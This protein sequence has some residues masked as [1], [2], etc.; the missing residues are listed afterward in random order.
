MISEFPTP[1]I[2]PPMHAGNHHNTMIFHFEEQ[3]VR[4]APH[5][6]SPYFAMHNLKAVGTLCDYLYCRL[7]CHCKPQSKISMYI[8][9]PCPPFPEVCIG[10][11][12]P[13]DRQRHCFLNRSA[14][15]CFHGVTSFGSRSYCAM[16]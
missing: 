3:A 16:R 5:P 12:Y 10:L 11:G 14:L 9:V 1:R 8:L 13:D 2:A 4:E 6:C 7:H 15:T